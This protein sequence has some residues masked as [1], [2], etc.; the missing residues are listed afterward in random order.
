[1]AGNQMPLAA[2]MR[3]KSLDGI[4]GQKHVLGPDKLLY[5]AVKADK[6]ES[7]ILYG[8]PG[9]GKTTIAMAIANETSNAFVQINATT[10]GKKDMEKAVTD[11]RKL[12]RTDGL[13][14]VLFIDEI[15]RFNKAQQ[16]FLLPHVESGLVVL[17]GATT[18]NP[19]F[20]VNKALLS[21]SRIFELKPLDREDIRDLLLRAC[22]DPDGVPGTEIDPDALSFLSDA[23][24]GDV[25]GALNAL[26][27]G[28]LTTNPEPD[29]HVKITLDTA[30][31]C[32]QK[33]AVMYDKDG[34]AH[35]DCVSAYIESVRGS[36]PQAAL[37]YLARMLTAG[38]DIKYIARQLMFQACVDVGMAN[39]QAL[40]VAASCAF[41][42]DWIG[43]P[44]AAYALAD[45]TIYIACSPKTPTVMQAMDAAMEC[46]KQTGA[47]PVP[48]MF[49]DA[50]Y[51][52]ATSLG[53]GVN[54]IC[55]YDYPNNYVTRQHLPDVL[56]TAW[57]YS[58]SRVGHEAEIAAHMNKLL[59]DERER[60]AAEARQKG[61]Q[62]SVTPRLKPEA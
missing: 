28:V 1:M 3:P 50:S 39:P 15:H 9:C 13:K 43:M 52:G 59:H 19:Y 17:I 12:M 18:E 44:R 61:D 24:S 27:L 8:P 2:R 57:F 46:V 34:D 49:K 51:K 42:C 55:N 7:M 40:C 56:K 20:E 14:T 60:L 30:Q 22:T 6:L 21:R 5:R 4:A 38:E 25:R 23:C 62:P 37:Y 54:F 31:E 35:Y 41:A 53:R 11:A 48:D 16:D 10:S 36:D 58:P 47:P 26:E 32:I 45:A 33:K 29:G